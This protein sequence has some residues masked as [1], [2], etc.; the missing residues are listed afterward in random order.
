MK[1]YDAKGIPTK[2]ILDEVTK[3][4]EIY[5]KEYAK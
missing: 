2:A 4:K 5:S 1:D 3:L